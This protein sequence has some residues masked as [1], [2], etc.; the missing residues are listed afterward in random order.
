VKQGRDVVRDKE[1]MV[2]ETAKRGKWKSNS[3]A[4]TREKYE[5]KSQIRKKQKKQHRRK[6]KNSIQY[7]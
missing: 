4:N 7:I 6:Q 1:I 5:K 2:V 3:I